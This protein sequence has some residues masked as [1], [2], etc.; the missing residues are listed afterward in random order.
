MRGRGASADFRTSAQRRISLSTAGTAGGR[1]PT[2]GKVVALTDLARLVGARGR[3]GRQIDRAQLRDPAAQHPHRPGQPIRSAITVAGMPGHEPAN[4]GSAAPPHRPPSPAGTGRYCGGPSLARALFTVFFEHPS[5]AI[6]TCAGIV[7]QDL[8]AERGTI[9]PWSICFRCVGMAGV[10]KSWIRAVQLDSDGVGDGC[11][12]GVEAVQGGGASVGEPTQS[13]VPDAGH[14]GRG[15]SNRWPARMWHTFG[16]VPGLPEGD[17]SK[18]EVFRLPRTTPPGSMN[19]VGLRAFG[20]R[21]L[22]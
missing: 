21:I 2:G 10:R 8:R 16:S 3:I 17:Q 6:A 13:D 19:Y 9:Q 1:G 7:G 22:S 12:V 14:G 18:R 5:I 11:R 20:R 15:R 4:P